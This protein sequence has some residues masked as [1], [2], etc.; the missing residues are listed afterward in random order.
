MTFHTYAG[1]RGYPAKDG[2]KA[3]RTLLNEVFI[4]SE[5]CKKLC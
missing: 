3:V 1:V 2:K 5:E 4:W